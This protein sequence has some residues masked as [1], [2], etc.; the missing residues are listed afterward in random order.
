MVG[1]TVPPRM[2]WHCRYV[3]NVYVREKTD[4][5][6]ALAVLF[7]YVG[8]LER[9]QCLAPTMDAVRALRQRPVHPAIVRASLRCESN[10][11][12]AMHTAAAQHQLQGR[13]EGG[14]YAP[15][16]EAAIEAV[17]K[18]LV[19]SVTDSVLHAMGDP[20]KNV[21]AEALFCFESLLKEI[22]RG[23]FGSHAQC[24]R[25]AELILALMQRQ[26]PCLI[27]DS[28]PDEDED[29]DDAFENDMDECV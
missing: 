24:T 26:A 13:P 25:A 14:G 20:R 11:C 10:V 23:V 8:T 27:N 4:A 15:G 12:V 21:V 16:E 5:L 19:H 18:E 6:D 17:V 3:S 2:V 22:G 28:E 1:N 29:D 9:T 7:T